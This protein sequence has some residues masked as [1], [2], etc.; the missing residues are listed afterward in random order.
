MGKGAKVIPRTTAVCAGKEEN[1]GVT[2]HSG[3]A[4][5]GKGTVIVP[6]ASQLTY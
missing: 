2:R 3:A 6:R 5:S 4:F 1:A